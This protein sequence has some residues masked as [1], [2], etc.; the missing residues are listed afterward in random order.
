[1]KNNRKKRVLFIV[2]PTGS[3]KTELSFKIAQKFNG[4]IICADSRQIYRKMNIG[5]AKPNDEERLQ[6]SHHLFDIRDPDEYFSAGEYAKLA[7]KTISEILRKNR[8]PVV[9]GGSGLYIK[10]LIDGVFEGD[11]KDQKLREQLNREAEKKGISFLYKRLSEVDPEQAKKIHFNDQ[12]R[13]IRSLE[14]YMLSGIKISKIQREKTISSQFYP[15]IIGLYWRRDQLY[16]RIN[17]RVDRMIHLG[18]VNE[19][20]NLIMQGYE[21]DLNSMNSVGYKEIISSLSGKISLEEAILLI[22][23]NTRRYAKRQMT[24]FK[25]DE[26]IHWI[27]LIEPVNWSSICRGISV[28][29]KYV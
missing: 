13:I 5:T 19:V 4:E 21:I 18:F 15:I 16:Q 17:Q 8:L 1:M 9:V 28:Q 25:K 12:K 27:N 26:R 2:G 14:V 24:W 6:I 23:R 11:F 7:K 22:K 3:G 20:K 29:L 10:A